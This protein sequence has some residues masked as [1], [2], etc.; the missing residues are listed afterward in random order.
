MSFKPGLYRHYSGNLYQAWGVGR[1]SERLEEMIIYQHLDGNCRL[2]GRPRTMFEGSVII[3]G[4]EKPR[5]E[6]MGPTFSEPPKL[7]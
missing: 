2:W 6:Y 4:K 1:H 7:R 5:F 3:D